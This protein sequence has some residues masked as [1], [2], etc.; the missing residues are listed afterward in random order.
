MRRTVAR[1][2]F[3]LVT[4][5]F[6][7][8]HFAGNRRLAR[9]LGSEAGALPAVGKS[10]TCNTGFHDEIRAQVFIDRLCLR[11]RLDNDRHL[12]MNASLLNFVSATRCRDSADGGV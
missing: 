1:A 4:D 8:R 11:R 6:V 5:F 9:S 10:R 3:R 2:S 12:P 7:R